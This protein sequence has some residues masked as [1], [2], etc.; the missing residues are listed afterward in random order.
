M[1]YP[2]DVIPPETRALYE[3][4]IWFP[5][6]VKPYMRG[7]L[8]F[9]YPSK[10]KY[11]TT[12]EIDHAVIAAGYVEK[13]GT[14]STSETQF[15]F[16]ERYGFVQ[17]LEKRKCTITGKMAFVVQATGKMPGPK[18]PKLHK[19]L[20]VSGDDPVELAWSIT[21][22]CQFAKEGGPARPDL[23]D[24][25][26][27]TFIEALKQKARLQ[28]RRPPPPKKSR[29]SDYI[30]ED[31]EAA[32]RAWAAARAAA[33]ARIDNIPFVGIQHLD[34]DEDKPKVREEFVHDRIPPLVAAGVIPPPPGIV[35]ELP[36]PPPPKKPEPI[37]LPGGVIL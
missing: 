10:S 21:R 32:T 27:T 7:I 6:K 35:F 28:A 13:V 23:V 33:V 8:D 22:L 26:T 17:Y 18:R 11:P 31:E 34:D 15:N 24:D 2:D 16:L 37:I 29:Y 4:C 14:R 12:T 30:D 5:P 1:R 25:N 9:G 36:P 19:K 3:S 20:V